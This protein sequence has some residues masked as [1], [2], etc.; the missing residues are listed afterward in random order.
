[1]YVEKARFL[2]FTFFFSLFKFIGSSDYILQSNCRS[3]C[4]F[5][6]N[7][8]AVRWF[9]FLCKCHHTHTTLAALKLSAEISS[10]CFC[11]RFF[12]HSYL[13]LSRVCDCLI[14]FT[15]S[16]Y[17][18]RLSR[19]IL[20]F[21]SRVL[22]WVLSSNFWHPRDCCNQPMTRAD[23]EVNKHSRDR[24]REAKREK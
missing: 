9:P 12:F 13:I 21:I 3:T 5:F 22:R 15:R 10:K 20:I 2:F 19:L 7:W 4:F 16:R 11:Y 6:V 18:F 23:G 8:F 1:M 17:V 24:E 14:S